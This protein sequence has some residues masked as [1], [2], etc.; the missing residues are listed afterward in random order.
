MEK[1]YSNPYTRMD[2]LRNIKGEFTLKRGEQTYTCSI[3]GD[4]L[5]KLKPE[6]D[7]ND[8]VI[9]NYLKYLQTEVFTE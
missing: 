1:Q 8:T 7:L 5:E 2:N 6:G 4:D 3:T 9:A